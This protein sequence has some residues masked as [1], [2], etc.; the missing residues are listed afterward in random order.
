MAEAPARLMAEAPTPLDNLV[1]QTLV[2]ST[3]IV[4][5]CTF[6]R[7]G[8]HPKV[9]DQAFCGQGSETPPE[10]LLDR[11]SGCNNRR[12]LCHDGGFRVQKRGNGVA[13]GMTGQQPL[14]VTI[15]SVGVRARMP[16]GGIFRSTS[17]HSRRN[18]WRI[19]RA[20]RQAG[21]RGLH[22]SLTRTSRRTRCFSL[23]K[24]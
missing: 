17:R 16:R 5:Y 22:R 6:G 11:I 24:R 9:S 10:I 18:R 13:C 4:D 8:N 3:K 21:S 2:R 20:S 14:S 19:L 1:G 7:A 15:V 12:F 23:G